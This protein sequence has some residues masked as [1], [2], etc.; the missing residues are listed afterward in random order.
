MKKILLLFVSLFFS[1]LALQASIKDYSVELVEQD[2][3]HVR[4]KFVLNDYQLLNQAEINNK[5]HQILHS[6]GGF[7]TLESGIPDLL[8]FTSNIQ[9]PDR[10]TSN[11]VIVNSSYNDLQNINIVPSKGSL[12]RNID[13]ST[14]PYVKGQVYN[15]NKFS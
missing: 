10:G 8:H 4:I 9:L 3:N 13:P 15:E 2:A 6:N 14:V 7:P 1:G 12:K 5:M 11:I